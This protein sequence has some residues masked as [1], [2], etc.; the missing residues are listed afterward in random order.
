MI[1]SRTNTPKCK[2]EHTLR[3]LCSFWLFFCP[4]FPLSHS[5]CMSQYRAAA[6]FMSTGCVTAVWL[7][8]FQPQ[9][10]VFSEEW[11]AEAWKSQTQE[12]SLWLTPSGLQLRNPF[13]REKSRWP[14]CGQ[15]RYGQT[16]FIQF[17]I[18]L[19]S[20]DVWSIASGSKLVLIWLEIIIL[21]FLSLGNTNPKTSE[22]ESR[23][24]SYI[25]SAASG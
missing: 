4:S 9:I 24:Y 12:V 25:V 10:Y 3:I 1:W 7:E 11:A 14:A 20:G 23:Q 18:C 16:A 13:W 2:C 5:Y 17:V 6:L 19:L 22:N 8:H 21:F 15:H